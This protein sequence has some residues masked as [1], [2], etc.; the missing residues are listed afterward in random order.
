MVIKPLALP[1]IIYSGCLPAYHSLVGF[2]PNQSIKYQTPPPPDA[3]VPPYSTN[4]SPGDPSC[5]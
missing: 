3:G 2:L 1:S 4:I 5:I